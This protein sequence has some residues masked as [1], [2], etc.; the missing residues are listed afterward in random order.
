M[1]TGSQALGAAMQYVQA[2]ANSLG[3]VKGAPC[4]IKSVNNTD[5]GAI[6]EFEW[7]GTNGQKQTSTLTIPAP[8]GFTQALLNQIHEAIR[9]GHD[10]ENKDALDTITADMIRQ[11]N[12]G[13]NIPDGNGVKY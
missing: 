7:V 5:A 6:V 12:E 13:L 10:H 8:E 3:A 11:W 9:L 1:L 2:T 4:T